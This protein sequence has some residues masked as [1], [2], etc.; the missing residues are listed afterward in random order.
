[1]WLN[2]K[3]VEEGLDHKYLQEM[4]RKYNSNHKNH[5]YK[6]VEEPK[7]QVNKSYIDKKNWQSKKLQIVE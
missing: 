5:S 1:M 3:H 2:E 4:K 6:L 7:K